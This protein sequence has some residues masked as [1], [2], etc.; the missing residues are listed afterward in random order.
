MSENQP[1][2]SIALRYFVLS[3]AITLAGCATD[4]NW[5]TSRS[6]ANFQQD[7]DACI[8][9][10]NTATVSGRGYDA[11][12]ATNPEISESYVPPINSACAGNF[13]LF[14]CNN[15]MPDTV[16]DMDR[17]LMSKGWRMKRVP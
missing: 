7:L 10:T 16:S 14:G 11:P 5:V 4:Y 13:G 15:G 12:D 1:L 3:V 9:I 8:R 6:D 17:C 2:L